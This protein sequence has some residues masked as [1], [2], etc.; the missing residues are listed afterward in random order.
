MQP[1][2]IA[3]SAMFMAGLS[4]GAKYMQIMSKVP[5]A[6]RDVIEA[7]IVLFVLWGFSLE[8]RKKSAEKERA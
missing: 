4:V 7:M 6:L 3:L 8:R 2:G 5:T 1:V